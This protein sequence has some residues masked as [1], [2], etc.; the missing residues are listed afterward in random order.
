VRTVPINRM[1]VRSFIVTPQ[2]GARLAAGRPVNL[3]GIAFDG[4]YGIGEV[5]ISSDN[6]TTWQ[7]T[8]LGKDLGRYSFRQWSGAWTPTRAGNH[9]LMV[10]AVNTV[11]ESQPATALWN[12]GGY[13]RNVVEQI[14]ITVV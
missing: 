4:G 6:G 12:P 2:N 11:G 5:Q 1:K 10:R 13:L 14:E 8:Q 7:R 9:R 3:K